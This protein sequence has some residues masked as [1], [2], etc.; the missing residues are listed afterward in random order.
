MDIV[1]TKQWVSCSMD[2]PERGE[3][4]EGDDKVSCASVAGSQ[5]MLQRDSVPFR[6]EAIIR[7]TG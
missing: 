2:C 1:L 5:L 7:S 6:R 3:A 4:S